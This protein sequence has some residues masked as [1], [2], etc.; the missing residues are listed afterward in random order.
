M[1]QFLKRRRVS[2]LSLVRSCSAGPVCIKCMYL[3]LHVYKAVC[4][5][6]RSVQ[7]AVCMYPLRGLALGLIMV[8]L[9]LSSFLVDIVMK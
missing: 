3:P 1:V 6:C 4:V 9:A 5:V 8:D 2:C 7:A